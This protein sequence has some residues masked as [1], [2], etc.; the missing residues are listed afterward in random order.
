MA[1]PEP[2][3]LY[4]PQHSL[5]DLKRRLQH[6][7]LPDHI[8][9]VGWNMGTEPTYLQVCHRLSRFTFHTRLNYHILL[10]HHI[11]YAAAELLHW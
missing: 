8:P 2:F 5:D 11:L 6:T 9:G 4:M 3:T 10:H 1:S 7:R